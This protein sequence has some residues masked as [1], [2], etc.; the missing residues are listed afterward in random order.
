MI[1]P[2]DGKYR[3]LSNF[4]VSDVEYEGVIYKTAEHAFQAAKSLNPERRKWVEEA[5]YPAQ[6]KKR[7]RQLVI[8]EDW[9][10]VRISIM[11]EILINKF[12]KSPLKEML[13][14]TGDEEL[15]EVNW[16]GDKFWGACDG[17][18]ENNLGKLLMKVRNKL[19]ILEVDE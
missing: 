12:A 6:A 18:G 5:E 14:D 17:C 1:G 11:E 15:V 7:G 10:D 4:Y 3:W 9:E 16:W 2:F 8:R 19:K 13:L